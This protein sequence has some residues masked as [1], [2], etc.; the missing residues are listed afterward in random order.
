MPR[1]YFATQNSCKHAKECLKF[2]DNLGDRLQRTR[3]CFGPRMQT[4]LYRTF[5]YRVPRW[6]YKRNRMTRN[7]IEV[8]V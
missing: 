2:T 1:P 6:L 8:I 5:T 3:L 7:R 4:E